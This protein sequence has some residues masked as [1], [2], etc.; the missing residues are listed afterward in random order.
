MI[1]L[2]DLTLFPPN[3]RGGVLCV[4]N[5]DGVHVGHS[6]ML[7]TGRQLADQMRCPFIIM[8]F[9]P[10][11][12]ILLKPNTDRRPLST[13]EQRHELLAQFSP[14]A[15]IIIPTTPEFLAISADDFLRTIIHDRLATRHFVEGQNFTFGHFAQGNVSTL[16]QQ[17]PQLGF[18]VTCVPLVTRSLSDCTLVN[19]SSSLIRWLVEQ[20]RVADAARCLGRPYTLRGPVVE[21]FKRGRTIGFPTANVATTQLIP[22]SGIYSGAAVLPSG[23]SH[24]AAISIGTN[25][26]FAG[27]TITVEAFLL[28]FSADLYG[29]TID[30]QFHHW[31]R[32]MVKFAGVNPLVQQMQRDV[33]RVRQ[34]SLQRAT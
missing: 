13:I 4:G 24:P 25:P 17:G 30:L 6:L 21:G 33:Q 8:T 5:F 20:G 28:D 12:S 23:Q 15:I 31:I 32:E 29:Q 10:H 18:G 11:P 27:K 9:D 3:L 34:F 2:S 1:V 16:E 19:V 22:A 14:D 7:Q 26:T